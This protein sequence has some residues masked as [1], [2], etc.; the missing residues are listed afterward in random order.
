MRGAPQKTD[1]KW[2]HAARVCSVRGLREWQ[3]RVCVRIRA[4]GALEDADGETDAQ[5]GEG[6]HKGGHQRHCVPQPLQAELL[7]SFKTKD[8]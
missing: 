1:S 8:T 7:R 2:P 5:E 3:R 4:R 6:H